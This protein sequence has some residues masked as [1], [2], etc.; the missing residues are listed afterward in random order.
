M[1]MRHILPIIIGTFRNCFKILVVTGVL[2]SFLTPAFA[3]DSETGTH[4]PWGIAMGYRMARIPYPSAEQQVSDVVPLLFYENKYVFIRGLEG[5]IKLYDKER[6]RFS[7]IGRYRFFDIP[8]EYQN[9][10]RG[11]GLDFGIQTK[12]RI[13]ETLE[14]NIEVMSD[15]R[16]RFFTNLNGRNTWESGSWRLMPYATL[17]YKGSRFN[18]RYFGLNGF[19]DPSNPGT[20][21]RNQ[22]GDGWDMTAGFEVRYHVISNLYLLGRTQIT[23][24]LDGSTRDS[25]SIDDKTYGEVY[26]GFAFFE[27]QTKPK[28]PELE[29]TPYLRF[30]FGYATP[31]NMGEILFEWDV[32]KD[33]QRN[34]LMS[35][36]YGHPVAD[37]L[38]GIREFD[39][40]ITPGF[41]YHLDAS[42][43]TDPD[44]GIT[45]DSQPTAEFVL[46]MKF[47][48]TVEWPILWRLGAAEG[49]SYAHEVT[50][51]EQ[52]EMDQ[53]GYRASNLLNFIDIS[54]DFNLG[55]LFR[56]NSM[57]SLWFGYSL[58]HRSAIFETASA[59]GRIKG[60]S[61]YNTLYL[62][63][64]F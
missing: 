21:F 17:R 48:Y 10:I 45:Y 16:G 6:T 26:V 8:A 40:Y 32:E 13:T 47:F 56:A 19:N 22:I 29:A 61:N 18:E 43:Y 54:I 57:R 49:I 38:F 11:D 2:C 7:L 34:K 3:D 27:D 64:H 24:L 33:P 30:A 58:H 36:F 55:D 42:P 44:S 60:G 51:L 53:K 4:E 1:Q 14:T 46:A 12:Y 41:V 35:V 20:T 63:Y 25:A 31:S 52:R 28:Q 37:S 23:S 62:Q 5:G 15:D 39:V 50:N 59:F 9:E